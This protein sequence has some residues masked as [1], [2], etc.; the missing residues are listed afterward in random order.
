MVLISV[1]D[2]RTRALE[3]R[4]LPLGPISFIFMQFSA[5]I[6]SIWDWHPRPLGNPKSATGY[7]Q[8]LFHL[9][10]KLTMLT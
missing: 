9:T 3:T 4:L 7:L 6:L 8:N 1:L 10:Q 2:P 5:K